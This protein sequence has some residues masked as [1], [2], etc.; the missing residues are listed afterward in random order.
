MALNPLVALAISVALIIGL[1]GVL[2]LH[3]FF[4]LIIAAAAVGLMTAGERSGGAVIETMMGEFG[5]SAGKIGFSIAIAAVIGAAL[6]ESGAADRIVRSFIAVLGE[7]RAPLALFS[8]GFV[9]G[10]PV[11]FDT[12]FFLLVPLARALSARTGRNYLLH[13]LA[14]CTGGVITHATVPPT[15]GPLA[16]A[17]ILRL[18]LGAALVG[19]L[20]AGLLPAAA[21]LAFAA[22]LNRRNP[23]PLRSTPGSPVATGAKAVEQ[24]EQDLPGFALSVAPVVLPVVL[25]AAVSVAATFRS[26]VSPDAMRVLELLGNK[27]VA[28]FFGA[29]IAVGV[30]L[31]QKGLGWRQTG[32]VVGEPLA[33]AGVIVFITAA[34]GAYGAMIKNAGVGEL[35]KGWAEAQGLN[36]LVLAWCMA[37]LLRA[38]QGST[39]VAVITTSGLMMSLGGSQAFGVHP[40]CLYVAIGYGG[41]FLSWMN[42]SGFWLFS[43]MSGLD[44]RE[45]LRSWTPLLCVISLVGLAEAWVLSL[46]LPVAR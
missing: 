14:I 41:V 18:D 43:R 6:L 36:V 22:W 27:N 37:A 38:A 25:I 42:D 26:S 20:A 31:R 9:L 5:A 24:S 44:E 29:I 7:K 19:G 1:I 39:T 30:Y 13:L 33:P 23:A 32:H 45:T 3:A 12:V 4:A 2:R 10:V 8:A 40:F 11:F 17:E 21:G 16:V 46:F 34:G 28:L 15:P 35:I